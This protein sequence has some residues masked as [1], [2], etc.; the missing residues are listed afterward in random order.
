MIEIC[1]RPAEPNGGSGA[2]RR[3]TSARADQ[4]IDGRLREFVVKSE[5]L[6]PETARLLEE[7]FMR[8]KI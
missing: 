5:A 4:T 7:V 8:G 6:K 1:H 2:Q 3:P